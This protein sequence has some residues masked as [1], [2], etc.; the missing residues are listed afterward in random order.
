MTTDPEVLVDDAS[1]PA[2]PSKTSSVVK[3]TI[4]WQLP[5]DPRAAQLHD[6]R[7]DRAELN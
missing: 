1:L 5:G 2:A 4:F 3:V 7:R 6:D